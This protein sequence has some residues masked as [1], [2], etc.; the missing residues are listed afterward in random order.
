MRLTDRS[1]QLEDAE[2]HGK[3]LVVPIYA[4]LQPEQ[5]AN[6]F[7]PTPP[8]MRKV[9]SLAL[10]LRPHALFADV[11]PMHCLRECWA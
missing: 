4:A 5:Q 9:G 10:L 7:K 2:S 11:F 1:L 3:L 6:V 8:G